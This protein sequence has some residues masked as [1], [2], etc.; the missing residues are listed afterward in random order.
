MVEVN[1]SRNSTQKDSSPS[2]FD[3]VLLKVFNVCIHPPR[4]PKI[5]EVLWQLPIFD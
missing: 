3:F 4:D 1:L 2:I 5:I